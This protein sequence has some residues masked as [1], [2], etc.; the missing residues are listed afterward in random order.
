MDPWR[1]CTGGLGRFGDRVPVGGPWAV[2][3]E[4]VVEAVFVAEVAVVV[5]GVVAG[6]LNGWVVG[7][8]VVGGAVVM[9]LV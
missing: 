5:V 2:G 1:V 3:R 7:R 6:H 4:V 8:V 9:G